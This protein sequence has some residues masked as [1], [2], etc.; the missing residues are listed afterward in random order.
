MTSVLST[1]SPILCV[2]LVLAAVC[3][4]PAVSAQAAP[5]VAPASDANLRVY[6]YVDISATPNLPTGNVA[7]TFSAWVYVTSLAAANTIV[8]F[9][10]AVGDCSSD[11]MH[12]FVQN[13]ASAEK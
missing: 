1:A 11:E 13:G 4:L 7:R 6:S 5:A 8:S 10:A 9:D 2:L 12:F 3:S